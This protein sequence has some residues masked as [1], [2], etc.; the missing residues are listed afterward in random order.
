MSSSLAVGGGYGLARNRSTPSND[1][2]ATV[3]YSLGVGSSPIAPVVLGGLVRGTTFVG[4]G[5]D[6]GLAIRGSN[7]GFARGDWGVA[8]DAGVVFRPW[9][10]GAYG[11]WPLQAVVTLGAPWGLQLA[12]GGQ[13]SSISGG[14]PARGFFATLEIDLLRLTVMRQGTT[15]IWWPNPAPAGGHEETARF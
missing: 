10:G 5:T 8:I 15:E 9:S 12:L 11:E 1:S 3:G 6:L 2:A 7:G 14:V 4:L 13:L